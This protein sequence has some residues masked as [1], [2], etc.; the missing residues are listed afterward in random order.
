MRKQRHQGYYSTQL[1]V[2]VNW[3]TWPLSVAVLALWRQS[4]CSG[5][6]LQWQQRQ[7]EPPSPSLGPPG[8]QVQINVGCLHPALPGDC[9]KATSSE[10]CCFLSPRPCK[11]K[12]MVLLSLEQNNTNAWFPFKMRRIS[13]VFYVHACS[14]KIKKDKP[15]F[16]YNPVNG[17]SHLVLLFILQLVYCYI[18]C[19]STCLFLI[20][21]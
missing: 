12:K 10:H 5:R 18:N 17:L 21:Y 16:L 8:L 7:S 2:P 19:W 15:R 14:P 13:K 1:K 9:Q 3:G 11:K 20:K 4:W 6:L